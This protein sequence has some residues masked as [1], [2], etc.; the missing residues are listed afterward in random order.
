MLERL[1]GRMIECKLE[2]HPEKSRLVY[3]RSD[4]YSERH[5]NES[6]DF[7]GYTFRRR[8][9]RTKAGKFFNGFTPAVSKAACQ[10]LRDK[11]RDILRNNKMIPLEDLANIMNP[12]IRGW[13]NYFSKFCASEARKILDYV[14]LSLVRWVKFKYK[15]VKRNLGKA[16]RY[17]VRMARANPRLFYH[18]QMGILPTMR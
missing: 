2:I 8:L 9:T 5:E 11:V 4:R 12:I 3:C 16:F 10:S 13:T 18:W 17:L 15:A 6:F 1:K 14:N 7:L